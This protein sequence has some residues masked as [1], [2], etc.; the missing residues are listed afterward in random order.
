V[1]LLDGNNALRSQFVYPVGATTPSYLITG[2]SEYRIISDQTGSPRLV[3]NAGSGQVEEQIDY[4]A[5]GNATVSNVANGWDTSLMPFGF[6]GGLV[7]SDT[8][9]IH[10]GVRDYD[11]HTGAWTS[12]DPLGFGAGDTTLYSYA[13]DDPVNLSD[14]SGLGPN[15]DNQQAMDINVNKMGYDLT[16]M[17]KSISGPVAYD[18]TEMKKSITGPV[19]YDLTEMKK[20][21]SGPVAYDLTEMKKSIS[22]P[23]AYDLTEMK[24]SITGPVGWNLE[25][26]QT[27]WNLET[28]QTAWNLETNVKSVAESGS[29]ATG[30]A[31]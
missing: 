23:V 4:D 29:L 24:K 26:N 7:D 11:P 13:Q 6:G 5:F 27:A 21:I 31:V 18:L 10:L 14:P 30:G 20:S 1:A 28:N 12:R 8:G 9:L 3:V 17:K 25:T 15:Q 16:E 19:A 22:G 2:G